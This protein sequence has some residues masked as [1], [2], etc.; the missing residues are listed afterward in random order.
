MPSYKTIVL[1]ADAA[2][3]ESA[4]FAAQRILARFDENREV[5]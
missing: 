3:P 2:S 1:V 5:A 4:L